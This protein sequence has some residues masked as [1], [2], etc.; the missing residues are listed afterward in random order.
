MPVAISPRNND[1]LLMQMDGSLTKDEFEK[2]LG[3]V[4][5]AGAEITKI[6]RDAL[7]ARYK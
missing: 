6:Q 4:L 5:A 3:M 1:V 7:E 2:A